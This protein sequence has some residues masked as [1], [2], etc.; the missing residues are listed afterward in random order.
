M[1]NFCGIVFLVAALGVAACAT[2]TAASPAAGAGQS[3]GPSVAA[4]VTPA[5]LE[6]AM[7]DIVTTNTALTKNAA[8][9]LAAAV[10]DGKKLAELFGTVERFF[11]QHNRADAVTLAQDA[12]RYASEAGG[13]AAAG[14]GVK[15]QAA[16]KNLSGQ[17]KQCHGL[18]REGDAA[19]GY[20]LKPGAIPGL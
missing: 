11:A 3:T 13:A 10:D 16:T 5:E 19:G 7:K 4:K 8:G 6:A 14:D 2:R 1:R 12:R 18:Y 20:R 17:C 9:N 15:A